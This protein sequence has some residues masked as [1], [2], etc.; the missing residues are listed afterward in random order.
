VVL[1]LIQKEDKM[2]IERLE[3][4]VKF[5]NAHDAIKVSLYFVV[6]YMD[7]NTDC[8]ELDDYQYTI[9]IV[10]MGGEFD[11]YRFL[12]IIESNSFE[13]SDSFLK[14]T[15]E[16]EVILHYRGHIIYIPISWVLERKE[17]ADEKLLWI[18]YDF[19]EKGEKY[20]REMLLNYLRKGDT[21]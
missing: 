6:P 5:N 4:L 17:D 20:Y 9:N 12:K 15:G 2:K 7:F 16:Q 8:D 1:D 18:G 21:K 3:E 10:L 13:I 11:P 19:F 14:S